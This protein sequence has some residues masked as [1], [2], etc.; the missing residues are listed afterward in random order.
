MEPPTAFVG[1]LRA[2]CGRPDHAGL[3]GRK[4]RGQLAGRRP[5][6]TEKTVEVNRDALRP[7]FAAIGTISLR[8][9]TVHDVRTALSK[10]AATHSTRTPQR[11]TTA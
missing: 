7:P 3:H 8:D 4:G 6:R 1:T 11:P 2:R 9:L 10:M 5:S